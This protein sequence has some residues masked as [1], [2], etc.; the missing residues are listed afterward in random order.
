VKKL[1]NDFDEAKN[2]L[3]AGSDWLIKEK[4]KCK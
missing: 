3:S 4:K 2:E 1:I